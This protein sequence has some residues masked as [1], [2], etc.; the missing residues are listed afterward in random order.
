MTQTTQ[1][2][3]IP[4]EGLRH[5]ARDVVIT[6]IPTAQ[7]GYR[8][9]V[10][11]GGVF[12]AELSS[13]H[14]FETNALTEWH[15]LVAQHPAATITTA[16]TLAPAAKGVQTKVSDPGHTALVIAEMN[17]L[18]ERGGKPGQYSVRVLTALAKRRYLTLTYETGRRDA[19]KVVIGGTISASGR[20]RL[21]QLTAAERAAADFDARLAAALNPA[22]SAQLVNA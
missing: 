13:G 11:V 15:R 18:V 9:Q 3:T 5:E 8:I 4:A 17:G 21:G 2:L 10:R 14:V 1:P 22:T 12:N 20:V 7:A 19:R 6:A 16:P